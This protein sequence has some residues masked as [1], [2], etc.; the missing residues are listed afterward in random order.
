MEVAVSSDATQALRAR[1]PAGS[2][3]HP[4]SL[5]ET[6]M[7]K[8]PCILAVLLVVACGSGD[9][10]LATAAVRGDEKP[11]AAKPDG[12]LRL[13]KRTIHDAALGRDALTLLV[14]A[15]WKLEGGVRWQLEY[16]NLAAAAFT[17]RDPKSAAAL[18]VFPVIPGCWHESGSYGFIGPGQNYMGNVVAAVPRDPAAYARDWFVPGFR[19]GARIVRTDDLPAVAKVVERNVAEAGVSKR[20]RSARVQ[21]EYEEK[22]QPIAEDVYL[23][24]VVTTSPAVPGSSMWSLEHQYS[25]RA[26]KDRL[27]ALAPTFQ[28]LAS[29]MRIELAWYAGYLDVFKLWQQGQMRSIRAAGELSRAI[30]SANDAVLA[31]LRSTWQTRQ[32]AQD[33][34]SRGFS[35]AIRGTQT[36]ANSF[37]QRDVELPGGYDSVWASA[38][39]GYVFSNTAGFDPNVGDTVEWRRLESPR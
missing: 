21:L 16:S 23:T 17:V 4:P 30:S 38:S 34:A 12:V 2:L 24:L 37:E 19:R 11:A 6:R 18:E 32:A 13:E 25:F 15:G 8:S 39:G 33:R 26:E 9:V 1:E 31:S 20:V 10:S 29:S 7:P 5:P 27:D 28:A 14:P 35:D 3:G 36:Y 22:G